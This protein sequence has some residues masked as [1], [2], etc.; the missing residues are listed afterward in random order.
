MS[1][2]LKPC[3]TCKFS[4]GESHTGLRCIKD[5]NYDPAPIYSP[6]VGWKR[7]VLHKLQ[8]ED[9]RLACQGAWHEDSLWTRLKKYIATQMRCGH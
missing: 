2:Y 6:I 8:C 1:N 3:S 9:R 4:E 5:P 7:P